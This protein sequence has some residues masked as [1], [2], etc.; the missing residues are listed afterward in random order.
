MLPWYIQTVQLL[1]LFQF[2]NQLLLTDA[3]SID[4]SSQCNIF[5]PRCDQGGVRTSFCINDAVKCSQPPYQSSLGSSTLCPGGT[6]CCIIYNIDVPL[7]AVP[8]PDF[9]ASSDIRPL[10]PPSS[11]ESELGNQEL[12][13]TENNGV[14]LG[15]DR[16][17][18]NF[19]TLDD[20]H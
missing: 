1:Q 6:Y 10:L 8:S 18:D 2:P 12:L 14:A 15:G 5:A 17:T 20:Y 4:D 11:G 7:G 9:Y 3:H 19:A 13:Q 16:M